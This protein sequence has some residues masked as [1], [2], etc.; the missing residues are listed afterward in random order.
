[1]TIKVSV[2]L[3]SY[4]NFAFIYDALDSVLNQNYK[5]IELLFCDDGSKLMDEK[6]LSEIHDYIFINNGDGYIDFKN[7]SSPVNVGIIKNFNNVIEHSTGDIIIPLSAD[8]ILNGED[9]IQNIVDEFEKNKT[10][11]FA[12]AFRQVIDRDDKTKRQILPTFEE[13]RLITDTPANLFKYLCIDNPIC[14]ATIYYRRE[15]FSKHGLFDE[16]FVLVEDYSKCLD[17]I[18]KGERI[19][20]INKVLLQYRLGGVSEAKP[21]AFHQDMKNIREKLIN[22]YI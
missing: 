7:Y 14:G 13:V 12:T 4:N 15:F 9:T 20:F 21:K 17:V 1:M 16:S 11:L 22:P 18:K 6:K 5:N 8:D 2:I 10:M 19:G 3:M